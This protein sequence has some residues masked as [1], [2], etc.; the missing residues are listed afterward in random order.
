M[1]R[2]RTCN[3][4]LKQLWPIAQGS[5]CEEHWKHP[6]RIFNTATTR[7]MTCLP[8]LKSFS[9]H[10]PQSS[11]QVLKSQRNPFFFKKK[12]RTTSLLPSP[13]SVT[14][15][16]HPHNYTWPC[17]TL[18]LS[19]SRESPVMSP[20]SRKTLAS[21]LLPD[22][23]HVPGLFMSNRCG[24]LLNRVSCALPRPRTP[25]DWDREQVCFTNL[26]NPVLSSWLSYF[27][28]S[29]FIDSWTETC[30]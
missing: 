20:I 24:L 9:G 13:I 8:F 22:P 4:D 19:V 30:T 26:Q 16:T 2:A 5:H 15:H 3:R 29:G 25:G 27:L 10:L 17:P 21:T 11:S 6:P 14:C 7:K 28:L 18:N 1:K 23:S 12:K